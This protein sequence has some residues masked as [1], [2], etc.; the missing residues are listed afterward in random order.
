MK[1]QD[2]VLLDYFAITVRAGKRSGLPRTQY[3]C[4]NTIRETLVFLEIE[5]TQEE[6][7]NKA[8]RRLQN[9]FI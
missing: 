8:Q 5:S 9:N 6:A 4:L 3:F 2:L 7:D 1:H